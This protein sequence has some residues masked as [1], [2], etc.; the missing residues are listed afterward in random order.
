[1]AD[2]AFWRD[3][4]GRRPRPQFVVRKLLC[5]IA[6]RYS[7]AFRGRSTKPIG[8]PLAMERTTKMAVGDSMEDM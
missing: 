5:G 7:H 3:G 2:F 1:M 6:L 8:T 4:H